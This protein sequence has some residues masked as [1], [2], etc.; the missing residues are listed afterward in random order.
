M[1]IFRTKNFIVESAELPHVDRGDGGH[2]RILPKKKVLDRQHLSP[3]LAIELMRLTTVAGEAMTSVMTKHGVPIGR[4]NYQ[5]M[6]NWKHFFHYHLYGRATNAKYQ[7][8]GETIFTPRR[9]KFP[10]YYER[11][12]PLTKKDETGIKKE[13]IRLLKTKKYSDSAWKLNNH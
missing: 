5:D 6:G 1:E 3:P 11:F 4:I 2:I 13:I 9:D 12:K 8:Y 7:E 10:E